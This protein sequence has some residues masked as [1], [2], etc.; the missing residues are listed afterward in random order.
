M[1]INTDWK[2]DPVIGC[3]TREDAEGATSNAVHLVLAAMRENGIPT[4]DELA[5]IIFNN[6]AVAI[7]FGLVDVLKHLVEHVGIDINANTCSNF[8][9]GQPYHLLFH[10]IMHEESAC[11]EY[12]ML[13][14]KI[15]MNSPVVPVPTYNNPEN[16]HFGGW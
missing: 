6:P 16:V 8:S 15:D 2:D 10:A 9:S 12:L 5:P 7:E 14:Q 3:V 13:N 4:A 11:I 1:T